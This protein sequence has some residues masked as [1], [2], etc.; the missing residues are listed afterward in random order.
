[1]CVGHKKRDLSDVRVVKRLGSRVDI[2]GGVVIVEGRPCHCRGRQ[3]VIHQSRAYV[4]KLSDV[5]NIAELIDEGKEMGRNGRVN[6]EVADS[7]YEG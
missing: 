2:E 5:N 1:M 6:A 4:R 7:T 3:R